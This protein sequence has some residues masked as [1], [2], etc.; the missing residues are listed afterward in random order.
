MRFGRWTVVGLTPGTNSRNRKW[1]CIC[2]CGNAKSVRG[3][4]LTSGISRSCGC[5]QREL[6]GDRARKHGGFGT[7]LYNIWN[8]MRQRCNNPNH[9]AYKNYGGR[10]ITICVE[11]NDYEA[12]R[13]WAYSVGYKDDAPR[14]EYTLD[15]I[16]VNGPYAP[17]NCRFSD[18]VEQANN[19]RESIW[20]EHNGE[21]HPLTEWAEIIGE[22][23]CVLWAR[24][25]RGEQ[26]FTD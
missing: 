2:D 15:R 6:V 9:H 4:S 17:S 19:R 12:F 25:R 24:Y 11:W 16:D 13:D 7:R 23:Y 8:S 21:Y 1:D 10:G 18:M 14:G 5:L 3:S 26:I 22:K 20:I